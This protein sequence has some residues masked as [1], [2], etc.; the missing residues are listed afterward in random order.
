MKKITIISILTVLLTL[1]MQSSLA[2][3][4]SLTTQQQQPSFYQK[5]LDKASSIKRKLGNIDEPTKQA[6][7]NVAFGTA[8]ALI[9]N[10][11]TSSMQDQST[12]SPSS[13]FQESIKKGYTEPTTGHD[14]P[15]PS[16]EISQ[17]NYYETLGLNQNASQSE[18]R[19]AYLNLA[20]QYHPDKNP[21]NDAAEAK[22]K[23]IGE[24]YEA[25][26]E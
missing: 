18:I 17:S 23:E 14:Q 7:A 3:D 13:G 9:T 4:S 22:F 2:D 10:Y 11:V 21:G 20:R 8:Q 12:A 1:T 26:S 19:R 15:N 16:E 5:A 6:L 24:A 25:L